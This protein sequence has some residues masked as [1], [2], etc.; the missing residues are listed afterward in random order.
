MARPDLLAAVAQ[1]I[2]I[3]ICIYENIIC[4][5]TCIFMY[6]CIYIHVSFACVT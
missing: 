6:I 5:Y 3:Y 1:N 2:Y 4:I